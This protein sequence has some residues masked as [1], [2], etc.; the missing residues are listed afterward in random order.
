MEADHATEV[1]EI[2]AE[3]EEAM[4]ETREEAKV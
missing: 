3:W 1:E 2:E 4:D